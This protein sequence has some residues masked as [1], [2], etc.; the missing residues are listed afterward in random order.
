MMAMPSALVSWV[1]EVMSR[2]V[3]TAQTPRACSFSSAPNANSLVRIVQMAVSWRLVTASLAELAGEDGD[4]SPVSWSDAVPGAPADDD[5]PEVVGPSS[6]PGSGGS[7][8]P[9]SCR[10]PLAAGVAACVLAAG[11]GGAVLGARW[12]RW[13]VRAFGASIAGVV[14]LV[15]SGRG[16]DGHAR[17]CDDAAVLEDLLRGQAERRVREQDVAQLAAGTGLEHPLRVRLPDV[18]ARELRLAGHV[19]VPLDRHPAV[20]PLAAAADH[21]AGGRRLVDDDLVPGGQGAGPLVL[22]AERRDALHHVD[23]LQRLHWAD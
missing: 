19:H 23:G 13:A 1:V 3:I 22:S 21:A 4:D 20:R 12:A 9:A 8:P 11:A 17:L 18:L 2:P 14:P 6:S 7:A 5:A 16:V 10:G 15:T